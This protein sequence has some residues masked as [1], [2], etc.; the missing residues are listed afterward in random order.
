MKFKL[1]LSILLIAFYSLAKAQVSKSDFEKAINFFNCKAVELSLEDAKVNLQQFK[2]NCDCI[3]YPDYKEIKSSI[4]K[5]VTLTIKLSEEIEKLKTKEYKPYITSQDA[6]KLITEDIFKDDTE[7]RKIAEFANKRSDDNSFAVFLSNLK[8]EINLILS[9]PSSQEVNGVEEN[10]NQSNY[11]GSLNNRISKIEQ[12]LKRNKPKKKTWFDGITFQIDIFSIFISLLITILIIW[13]VIR[14]FN[15]A[16]S[17][18]ST[19]VKNYVKERISLSISEKE[20]QYLRTNSSELLELSKRVRYLENEIKM[21]TD[22]N[23]SL[24]N[25]IQSP[26][27]QKEPD[28][29]DKV[30]IFYLSTPNADG[31]FN[32]RSASATYREGAS[33]YRFTRTSMNRA[34]FQLDE[35]E[36]SIKLALQYPDRNIDPVCDAENAFNPKAKTIITN[37]AGEAE[38]VGDKWFKNKKAKI[39]YGN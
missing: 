22:K 23:I 25:S 17:E 14:S 38:L 5:A 3:R 30:E 28:E 4:P 12:E 8:K 24:K 35:R 10:L 39:R 27:D 19:N 13:L 16:E 31:S 21:M 20:N 34:R 1:I 18:I 26:Y 33:I 9:K 36:A 6:I 15:N 29:I 37:S 32:E 2:K 11:S 7:Y